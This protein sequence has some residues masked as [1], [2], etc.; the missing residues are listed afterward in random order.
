MSKKTQGGKDECQALDFFQATR[1]LLEECR[2]V[3][4]GIQA[5]F[6]FQLIAVFNEGFA[7]KLSVLDQRLHLAAIALIVIAIAIIMTPAAYHRQTAPL[8][9]SERL[10]RLSTRLLLWSMLPLT[11]GI[12]I[13]F[14]VVSAVIVDGNLARWLAAVVFLVFVGLW[15]V[16][17]R[18]Q[19]LQGILLHAK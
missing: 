9:A 14:Y 3:L 8:Q 5:L 13:D 16:L 19:A 11:L 10:V 18:A 7:Q 6:G 4:P 17:P 1:L 12:C 15:Y 2:M